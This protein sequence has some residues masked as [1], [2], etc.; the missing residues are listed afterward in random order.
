[1][2]QQHNRTLLFV[3]PRC[4]NVSMVTF[5]PVPM[6]NLP[7]VEMVQWN[8]LTYSCHSALPYLFYWLFSCFPPLLP[9]LSCS[10]LIFTYLLFYFDMY[11][12]PFSA[13]V[14]SF[15]SLF[16]TVIVFQ[17]KSYHPETSLNVQVTPSFIKLDCYLSRTTA[18]MIK[19]KFFLME[20]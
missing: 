12:S 5:L 16:K 2:R 7:Y 6:L 9:C 18:N 20:Y 17:Q 15:L 4:P 3:Q 11:P 10:D 14:I 8:S 13:S 19:L 1:M